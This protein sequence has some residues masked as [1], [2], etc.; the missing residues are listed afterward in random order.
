MLTKILIY[1]EDKYYNCAIELYLEVSLNVFSD[2]VRKNINERIRRE[3]MK[4]EVCCDNHEEILEI[5]TCPRLGEPAPDFEARTTHGNIK[6]SEFNRGSWVVLFSHL[7]TSLPS[8][9]QSLLALPKSNRN[10]QKKCQTS[11]IEH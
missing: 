4:E 6:F 5:C 3:K 8:A 1:S 9:L 10:F 7:Q 2:Y 11:G